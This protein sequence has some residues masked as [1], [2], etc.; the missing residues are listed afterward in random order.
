M[1]IKYEDL[2]LETENKLQNL[3]GE[4]EKEKQVIL[5]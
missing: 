1:E 5:K 4:F 2:K 3:K